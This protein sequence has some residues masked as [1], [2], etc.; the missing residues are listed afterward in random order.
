[1]QCDQK[2]EQN[3][4]KTGIYGYIYYILLIKNFHMNIKLYIAIQIQKNYI[5][6]KKFIKQSSFTVQIYYIIN[7]CQK[8]EKIKKQHQQKKKQSNSTFSF[9]ASTI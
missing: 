2:T 3:E 1:M 6:F 5:I 8:F 9:Q 4:Q 7:I